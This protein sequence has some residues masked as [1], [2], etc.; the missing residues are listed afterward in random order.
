[1]CFEL[2][3]CASTTTTAPTW[4]RDEWVKRERRGR[5]GQTA[6]EWCVCLRGIKCKLELVVWCK[7]TWGCSSTGTTCS[8]YLQGIVCLCE[9]Q[10]GVLGLPTVWIPFD[11]LSVSCDD[12][13]CGAHGVRVAV[14][15]GGGYGDGS[16]GVYEVA[17]VPAKSDIFALSDLVIGCGLGG[18]LCDDDF[19][20]VSVGADGGGWNCACVVAGA[21]CYTIVCGASRS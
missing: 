20:R 21:T 16:G 11:A 12:A 7:E 10:I 2:F 14:F 3:E 19:T 13:V 8:V 15:T 1:M 5:K 17:K 4:T 18:W 6:S 9:G